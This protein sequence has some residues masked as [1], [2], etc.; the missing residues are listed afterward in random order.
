M[1]PQTP[2]WQ[3]DESIPVGSDFTSWEVVEAYDTFHRRFRDVDKENTAIIAG[4]DL[5]QGQVLVDIG[6]GTGAFALQAA[7]CCRQVYA[8]DVSAAMLDYTQR[9]AQSQGLSNIVC[10]QAGFLTYV[11]REDSVD[12]VTSS[13]ALHHLPDFWKQKALR[14]L[15]AMLRQGGRIFLA[16]V[17]FSGRDVE[18]AIARWIDKMAATAGPQVAER[19]QD[20]VRKEYSTWG[21][22]IEGLL[23]RAG[24]RID[25]AEY[26]DGVLAQYYGTKIEAC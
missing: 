18:A 22:I 5:Q 3:F 17:V 10:H 7:R 15:N 4:L 16:D 19:I 26:T 1:N 8:I 11:H 2:S 25:R 14:R 9:K 23:Q 13:M 21:W 24:F 6:C 20:H 12:A